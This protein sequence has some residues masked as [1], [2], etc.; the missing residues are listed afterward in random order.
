MLQVTVEDALQG[1]VDHVDCSVLHADVVH[2]LV[3][4]LQSRSVTLAVV[5]MLDVE[6]SPAD[7]VMVVAS[8]LQAV[9]LQ[10]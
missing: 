7:A 4:Q 3:F 8:L 1:H 9:L 6:W 5:A 2:V 10:W